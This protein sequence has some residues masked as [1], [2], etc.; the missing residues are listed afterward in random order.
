MK[1][2]RRIGAV[3]AWVVL[4]YMYVVV[5][6]VF[7]AQVHPGPIPRWILISMLCFFVAT[8]VVGSVVI[9]RTA[10]KL[11]KDETADEAKRRRAAATRGL[12]AGL[13]LYVLILL[14]GIRLIVQRTVPW[15]YA[16]PGLTIDIFLITV[17]WISL[18]RLKQIELNNQSMR[19]QIPQK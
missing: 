14:N 15:N 1:F 7:Y 12:K 11:A 13:V 3:L 5:A 19:Q 6:L 16:I 17:F 9:R 10:R 2:Q 18:R 4:P 8:I